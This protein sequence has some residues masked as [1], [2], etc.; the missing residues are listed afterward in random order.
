M[1]IKKRSATFSGKKFTPRENP[2]YDYV[3]TRQQNYFKC[4]LYVYLLYDNIQLHLNK[5]V[6]TEDIYQLHE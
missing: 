5:T 4:N 2:G 3:Q 1:T 6:D